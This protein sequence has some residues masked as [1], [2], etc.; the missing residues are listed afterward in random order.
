MY[1]H[2]SRHAMRDG[3]GAI[4]ET[5]LVAPPVVDACRRSTSLPLVGT[6]DRA[7]AYVPQKVW[8]TRSCVAGGSMYRA[9]AG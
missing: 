6:G 7:F 9:K 2:G 8:S 4:G 1:T 3:P 5:L